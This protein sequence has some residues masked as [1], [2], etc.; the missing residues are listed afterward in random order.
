MNG[1]LFTSENSAEIHAKW[2]DTVNQHAGHWFSLMLRIVIASGRYIWECFHISW[3]FTA[4]VRTF[5]W[6]FHEVGYED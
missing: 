5:E 1:L 2:K 4:Y 3:V 6:L